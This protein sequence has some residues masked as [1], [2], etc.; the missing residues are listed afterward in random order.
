MSQPPHAQQY[1][2]CPSCHV[3]ADEYRNLKA[4][5][6]TF[7]PRR[8]ELIALAAECTTIV[9]RGKVVSQRLVRLLSWF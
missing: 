9:A 4:Y 1:A 2:C 6:D 3:N 5:Y 8:V 7:E